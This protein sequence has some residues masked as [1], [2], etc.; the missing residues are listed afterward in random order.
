MEHFSG[1]LRLTGLD[2]FIGPSLACVNPTVME[3]TKKSALIELDD[4]GHLVEKHDSGSTSVLKTA[5]ISLTDCLACS[6]CITSAEA[7]LVSAQSVDEFLRLAAECRDLPS[8][9]LSLSENGRGSACRRLV[10]SVSPQAR[11]S[12]AA[13]FHSDIETTQRKLNDL[14]ARLGAVMVTDTTFSRDLAL[15]E[16]ALE[17]VDRFRVSGSTEMP[18]P[19]LASSC[20]GWI[21]FAEKTH[22]DFLLPYISTTKS[23]QQ[24]M[25]SLVK[26]VWGANHGLK[27]SQIVHVCVMPCFDKK[28]EA[29]RADFQDEE[30]NVPDVDCVITASEVLEL[31]QKQNIR[32]EELDSKHSPDDLVLSFV[33]RSAESGRLV[34]YHGSG[35]GGYAEFI[36]RHAAKELFGVDVQQIAWKQGRNPDVRETELIVDGKCV[37]RFGISNGFRNIQNL[38]RRVKSGKSEF[39]FVE[40]MACPG[41][42]L[43]GGGQ[44]KPAAG[45]TAQDV[46]ARVEELY[47]SVDHRDPD[48]N[49]V[50]HSLYR[51]V[52]A[53]TSQNRRLLHTR[54][55]A[56]EKLKNPFA[57]RW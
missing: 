36:F 12:I 30:G 26:E 53:N 24:I 8:P 10:V 38:V 42:C 9:P 47:Q 39:H 52:F 22:S 23:P 48:Q 51:S 28:L 20:P 7:L 57:I 50:V 44:C 37:L 15:M 55:H 3:R 40:V 19:M 1:A 17:F 31:L 25:G 13:H 49:A 35:S 56:I 33:P 46:L 11:A 41:G 14:F 54:Y 45:E 18:L 34:G 4:S 21:C 32:F 29:S 6:G 5:S 16:A 43:N 2:D 27:K